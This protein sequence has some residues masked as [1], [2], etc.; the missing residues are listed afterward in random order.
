MSSPQQI[1]VC[2]NREPASNRLARWDKTPWNGTGWI[3]EPAPVL[4]TI[5]APDWCRPAALWGMREWMK[6]CAIEVEWESNPRAA[7]I[8]LVEGPIDGPSGTLAYME[9]PYGPDKPLEGKV[10]TSEA[11][12]R[13]PSGAPNRG[14]IHLGAVLCHEYGH[15]L[16]IEHVPTS[17]GVALLNPMYRPD[18]LTPQELDAKQAVYRYGPPIA[19]TPDS[20]DP[21]P[22]LATIELSAALAPGVY[23]LVKQ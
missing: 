9:L 8:N 11:W 10:D 4:L 3:G 13:D 15:A 1:L 21:V 20:G 7:S 2:G 19:K 17:Q 18:V 14:Q 12:D 22:G 16:G 23:Q 6:V 5:H